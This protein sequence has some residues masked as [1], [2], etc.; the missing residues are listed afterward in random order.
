MKS[1]TWKCVPTPI[2]G[3][4]D[5]SEVSEC[6][7]QRGSQKLLQELVSHEF[8]AYVSVLTYF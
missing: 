8:T 3:G 2:S 6:H 4:V 1:C 5:I 7:S